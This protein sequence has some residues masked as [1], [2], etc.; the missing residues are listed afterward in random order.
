MTNYIQLIPLKKSGQK[1]LKY[2]KVKTNQITEENKL[3]YRVIF[4]SMPYGIIKLFAYFDTSVAKQL[5]NHPA[6]P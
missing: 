2:C 4:H 3:K 6:R 5:L 1:F